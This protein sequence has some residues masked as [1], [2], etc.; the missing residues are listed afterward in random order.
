[1]PWNEERAEHIS[2][3]KNRR[4]PLKLYMY[5]YFWNSISKPMSYTGPELPTMC[6]KNYC[7]SSRE[8]TRHTKWKRASN[9]FFGVKRGT[10]DVKCSRTF[11]PPSR[12]APKHSKSEHIFNTVTHPAVV[13]GRERTHFGKFAYAKIKSW[14]EVNT[15]GWGQNS[16]L[17]HSCLGQSSLNSDSLPQKY[18]WRLRF[19]FT[20]LAT[21]PT[22]R[23]QIPMCR[24]RR[25]SQHIAPRY[26]V[27]W[28]VPLI[29]FLVPDWTI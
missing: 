3:D 16:I 25:P 10:R 2:A 21:S 6:K 28:H 26:V 11:N 18:V 24:R 22:Q 5:K 17:K 4:A 14:I 19:P 8:P 29:P 7:T 15:V 12:V 23:S 27:R 20:E 9:L 13:L 1:M